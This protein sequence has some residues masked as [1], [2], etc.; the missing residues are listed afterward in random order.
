M[1]ALNR[2]PKILETVEQMNENHDIVKVFESYKK[3][4][5][6]FIASMKEEVSSLIKRY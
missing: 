6:I 5:R 4:V 2:I 3:N 1:E